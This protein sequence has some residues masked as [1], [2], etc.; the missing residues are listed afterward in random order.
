[1]DVFLYGDIGRNAKDFSTAFCLSPNLFNCLVQSKTAKVRKNNAQS[2]LRK[3][4]CRDATY[5]AGSSGDNGDTALFDCLALHA[6]PPQ[7]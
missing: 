4:V 7:V 5:A 6:E 1:M 2:R 3:P